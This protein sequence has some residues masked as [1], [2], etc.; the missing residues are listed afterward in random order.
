ME[1]R[2]HYYW[3]QERKGKDWISKEDCDIDED[4]VYIHEEIAIHI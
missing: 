3:A 1:Y 2:C 4:V